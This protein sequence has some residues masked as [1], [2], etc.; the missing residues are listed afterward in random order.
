LLVSCRREPATT[1]PAIESVGHAPAPVP[2][3]VPRPATTTSPP[4]EDLVTRP[5]VEDALWIR[6]GASEGEGKR[7]VI[8]RYRT[9][10]I[11]AEGE[12]RLRR[13]VARVDALGA[14]LVLA[15]PPS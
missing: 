12:P 7:V 13:H 4:A 6:L 8:G 2:A 11:T 9:V 3:P 10:R 15:Q 14:V 1:A 5:A